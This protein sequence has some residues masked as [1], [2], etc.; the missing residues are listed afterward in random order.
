[1][2]KSSQDIYQERV[3]KCL[4]LIIKKLQTDVGKRTV[5]RE[6]S[7]EFPDLFKN[8]EDAR[9]FI[10]RM[11]SSS[12][13]ATYSSFQLIRNTF[14]QL[15][16]DDMELIP[17]PYVIKDETV[18]IVNDIHSIFHEPK[19]LDTAINYLVQKNTEALFING[20][21]IDF[22]QLSKFQH[23]YDRAHFHKEREWG[24]RFLQEMQLIF[25]NVYWKKGNH[26][27]RW[28]TYMLSHAPI[29]FEMPEFRNIEYLFSYEGSTIKHVEHYRRV[30]IGKLNVIHGHEL[31]K[32]GGAVVNV[33]R[34][35]FLKGYQNVA[36]GH[37]HTVD[38]FAFKRFNGDVMMAWAIGCLCSHL[39]EYAPINQWFHGFAKVDKT[40]DDGH[41]I[42]NNKMIIDG[43][44]V[45]A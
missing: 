39:Q 24:I 8:I 13:K 30:E 7:N 9:T 36:L 31:G 5:A 26:E 41:F 33:A 40:S 12:G 4:S 3:S 27:H 28:E 45:K 34:R 10:R 18:G 6:L 11:T 35:A 15:E 21:L 20:D 19:A 17:E 1:M 37:H 2:G 14:G 32:S 23:R 42:F 25:K 43:K 44:I 29:L 16:V 22:Y 38:S